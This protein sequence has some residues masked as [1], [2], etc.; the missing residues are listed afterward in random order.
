MRRV[1]LVLALLWLAMIAMYCVCAQGQ[2]MNNPNAAISNTV[3]LTKAIAEHRTIPAGTLYVSGTATTEAKVGCGRLYSKGSFG[4]GGYP[5]DHAAVGSMTRVVQLGH[6]PIVRLSGDGFV[7]DDPIE[8]VG[9]GESA[10]FEVEGRADPPS[11]RHRF[12]N[13]I[14]TDCGAA[15]KCVA[16]PDEAHADMSLVEGCEFYNCDRVFWSCN[17]QALGW[18]FRSCAVNV[19]GTK[20]CIVAD[21]ERGGWLTFDGLTLNHPRVMLLR[22]RDYSPNNCDFVFRDVRRD[23]PTAPDNYLRLVDYVG[24]ES[25][26]ANCPWRIKMEVNA[27]GCDPKKLY[28]VP[29]TLPREGWHIEV[30]GVK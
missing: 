17:Q 15:F 2:S 22:V 3:W 28:C 14:F 13:Q 27:V 26:A 30:E 4:V 1:Y 21:I 10:A 7:A 9:D 11:G 19:L 24:D 29:A 5:S 6:G 18:T 8:W 23:I 12:R 25:Q 16:T 20:N